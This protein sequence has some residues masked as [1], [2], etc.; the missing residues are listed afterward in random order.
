MQV[1]GNLASIRIP[2]I[3]ERVDLPETAHMRGATAELTAALLNMIFIIVPFFESLNMIYKFK[4][5][6]T[7]GMAEF[8][9]MQCRR[10][11]S[12]RKNKIILIEIESVLLGAVETVKKSHKPIDYAKTTTLENLKVGTSDISK[13]VEKI[14]RTR[15][16]KAQEIC[17]ST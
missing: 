4:Y 3:V 11:R 5:F 1:S 13:A 10:R 6:F 14:W 16:E 9:T 8:S 2:S 17:L 7:A 12:L 15:C